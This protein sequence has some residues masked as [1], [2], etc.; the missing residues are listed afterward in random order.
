MSKKILLLLSCVFCLQFAVAQT[1]SDEQIINFV[2]KEQEKGS[3]QRT[4]ATKLLQ[5]GVS[6]E[7]LRDIKKKYENEKALSNASLLVGEKKNDSRSRETNDMFQE[8]KYT[9][10][11]NVAL[12]ENEM[13]FLD[14]DS[15]AFYRNLLE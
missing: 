5:K 9:G 11:E 10:D 1:M 12:L 15:V 4:I 7:R 6:P 3:D 13:S 8:K 2:V 14:I